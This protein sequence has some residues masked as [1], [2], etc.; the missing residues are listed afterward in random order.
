[1]S[2][3]SKWANIKRKKQANDQTK[4]NIFSKISRLITLSI[5]EGNN[6]ADPEHNVHLRLSIEK[7]KEMN[8]PKESIQRAIEK[9]LGPNKHFLKEVIYEVF[10]QGGIMLMIIATTD[11]SNRTTSEIKNILEKYQAKLGNQGSVSY[12]FQKCGIVTFNKS[13]AGESDVFDFAQR[14]E[15]F[16][17]DQDKEYYYVYFPFVHLGRIHEYSKGLIK[18]TAEIDYKPTTMIHVTDEKAVTKLLGLIEALEEHEDVHKV[19]GN[20]DIDSKFMNRYE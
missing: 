15:A 10:G 17:I 13:E 2:G 16:D 9:A 14:I 18:K 7:A 19:F 3:H 20:Y 12:L 5:L 8:M 11:N 4:G 1:M 6:I